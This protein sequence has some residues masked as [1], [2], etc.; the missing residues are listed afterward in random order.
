MQ[1]AQ[2]SWSV[3]LQADTSP[4]RRRTL[5]VVLL[6]DRLRR[7]SGVIQRGAD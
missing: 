2:S 6:E 5:R 1:N 4:V 7:Q 3:G